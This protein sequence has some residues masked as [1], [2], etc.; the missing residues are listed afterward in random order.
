MEF[1]GI[2]VGVLALICALVL[3]FGRRGTAKIL[4]WFAV[5]VVLGIGGTAGLI[6]WND[7]QTKRATAIQVTTPDGRQCPTDK[8]Y[9]SDV[10]RRCVQELSDRDVG[11]PDASSDAFDAKAA[12]TPVTILPALPSGFVLD[13]TADVAD[14]IAVTGPDKRIFLFA[15]RTEKAAIES[16]MQT[17]YGAPGTPRAQCWTKEPG[18]WCDYR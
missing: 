12:A 15:A 2:S 1:M 7:N 9:W 14:K 16:Y 11:L 17:Q 13:K 18:P 6:V 3:L 10:S 4:G 5:L 8:P